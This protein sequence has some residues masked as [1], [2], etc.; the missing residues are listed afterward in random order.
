MRLL[1]ITA[2]PDD[3]SGGFGGTLALYTARG[4]E[5]GVVC[6]TRGE[7]G[8]HRGN[9]TS[10]EEL[11]RVRAGEFH[12][13]CK[14]LG[15]SWQ[16]IYEYP[17]AGLT[18]VPL[19]DLGVRLCALIR[20]RRPDVV[21]TFGPD[22]AYTGHRDHAGISHHAT[23]GFHAAG[24]ETLFPEAG[25]PFAPARLYYLTGR[26]PLPGYPQVTF[27]PVDVEMDVSQTY[28]R[29]LE[30]F[31]HHGTQS[32]LFE[33]FR[34][35]TERSGPRE[36]FHLAASRDGRVEGIQHDLFAGLRATEALP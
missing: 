27:S 25:A 1:A 9:T 5:V 34:A 2:H 31:M 3:E 17:D 13:A 14:F 26:Q 6:A 32:P 7:A 28:A 4:V 22:G 36:Y 12:R 10:R 15:A 23:F 33:R 29:K 21:V 24:R 30:A 20:A 18:K 35:S 19:E 11:A 8:R 16:E